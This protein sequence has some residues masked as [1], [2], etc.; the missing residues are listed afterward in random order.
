MNEKHSPFIKTVVL[1][2]AHIEPVTSKLLLEHCEEN[3]VDT[4]SLIVFQ[5]SVYGFFIVVPDNPADP[6]NTDPI[7]LS[8]LPKDLMG[9]LEYAWENLCEWVMLDRD[10]EIIEELPTYDW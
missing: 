6:E 2:T 9:I 8:E 10:A 1:S 5:K 7:D 3:A 4:L